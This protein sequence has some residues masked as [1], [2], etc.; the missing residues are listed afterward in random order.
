M[1]LFRKTDIVII[2][3][4]VTVAAI[5]WVI[6]NGIFSGKAAKA[7][8]YYYSTL[9]ET[10]E[11]TG[12]Q[13][14][15]FSIPQNANVVLYIDNEGNIQFIKSNCPDKIC[16]R[17]GKLRIAGQSAACLPNGIV[18]KIVPAGEPGDDSPDIVIDR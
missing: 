4:I 3:V 13:E 17:T 15:K 16:I 9:V 8:I 5:F 18:V 12:G 11:L 6:Y 10:V 1:K 7:E 14:R 2:A